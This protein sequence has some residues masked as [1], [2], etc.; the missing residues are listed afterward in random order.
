[1]EKIRKCHGA[2]QANVSRVIAQ[3]FEFV[4]SN[5]WKVIWSTSTSNVLTGNSLE[6]PWP[7]KTSWNVTR[8]SAYQRRHRQILEIP[9]SSSI[10]SHHHEKKIT[11]FIFLKCFLSVKIPRLRSKLTSLKF[12]VSVWTVRQ[13]CEFSKPTPVTF[14]SSL[15]FSDWTRRLRVIKKLVVIIL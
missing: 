6:L 13:R 7:L 14:N 8:T 1:M 3:S 10:P 11:E 4:S 15:L 12:R 2:F 9:L 5:K